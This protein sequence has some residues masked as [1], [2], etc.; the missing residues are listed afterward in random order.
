MALCTG[1]SNLFCFRPER[2]VLEC[3]Y[4]MRALDL[5][6]TLRWLRESARETLKDYQREARTFPVSP[7]P[8][9]KPL[10]GMPGHCVVS[11]QPPWL[12]LTR[13]H[14]KIA[15]LPLV[16]QLICFRRQEEERLAMSSAFDR[17]LEKRYL[18][19][20]LRTLL[21]Y[22]HRTIFGHQQPIFDAL[23]VWASFVNEVEPDRD[24]DTQK[25]DY[26][27]AEHRILG[28]LFSGQQTCEEVSE[29]IVSAIELNFKEVLVG[30]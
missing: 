17:S 8:E 24:E 18:A 19:S 25:L 5:Y 12:Y 3:P 15:N 7:I 6:F 30:L 9:D 2:A 21:M 14:T 11:G 28:L 13:R 4:P 23:G 26:Y 29:S 10:L 1:I 22:R 20:G 27:L 16:F